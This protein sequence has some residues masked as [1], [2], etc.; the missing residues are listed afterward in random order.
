MDIF[1]DIE[2]RRSNNIPLLI[3]NKKKVYLSDIIKSDRSFLKNIS[4]GDVVI[5]IGDYDELSISTFLYLISIKAIIVPLTKANISDIEYNVKTTNADYIVEK[6]DVTR[7]KKKNASNYLIE[8]LKKKANPGLIFFSTGTTGKP[9]AILHDAALLF[10]RFETPRPALKAINFL[11]FDHM[12]GINTLLHIIFNGGTIISPQKRNPEYI[13]ELIKKYNIELLPTTPTFLRML[14]MSGIIPKDIPSCLNIITY[15]SEKMDESTLKTIC[16]LLPNVDF[17]QTYGLT[18]FSVLRLKSKSR[19]SLFFKIGG[20]GLETKVIGNT[21]YLKSKYRMEGYLN[22]DDPFDKDGW[23]NTKDIV[24]QNG[25]YIKIIGR[26]TDVVNVGGQKFILS[27]VE[28]VALKFPGV[29]DVKCIAKSNSITGQHVEILIEMIDT[30]YNDLNEIK[31]HFKKNLP[32][33]MRPQK[34]K[35]GKVEVNHRFKK[36]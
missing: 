2:K 33:H 7:I 6:Y 36:I 31:S 19:D 10:K 34:I 3:D 32:N 12:G 26:N 20:E 11:M 8:N 23:Y 29:S 28:S 13:L 27:E 25:E 18:E 16:N 14:L 5:L 17:R 30:K 22:A 24:E 15:G 9:K 21:L 4:P 35:I 1:K